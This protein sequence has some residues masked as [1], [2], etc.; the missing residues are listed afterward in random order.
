MVKIFHIFLTLLL[1]NNTFA[2]KPEDLTVRVG[3]TSVMVILVAVIAVVWKI[4]RS[5][6]D[7]RN[8]KSTH[9]SYIRQQSIPV[10][11]RP[12]TNRSSLVHRAPE[13]M[14]HLSFAQQMIRRN[15]FQGVPYHWK[16][17][18]WDTGFVI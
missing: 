15:K 6:L 18:F 17:L 3:A 8:T 1:P 16:K 4:I 2:A 11:S 10:Y 14:R 9:N 12:N 5:K 7:E 13:R